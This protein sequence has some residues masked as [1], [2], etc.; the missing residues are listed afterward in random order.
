MRKSE[1]VIC[2]K[3]HYDAYLQRPC[4]PFT[5]IQRLAAEEGRIKLA[6]SAWICCCTALHNLNVKLSTFI[7]VESGA[8]LFIALPVIIH[9]SIQINLQHIVKMSIL[10]TYACFELCMTSDDLGSSRKI[11]QVENILQYLSDM[12]ASF[13][14][15]TELTSDAVFNI[16]IWQDIVATN[17]RCFMP[18]SSKSWYLS[19]QK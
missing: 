11:K 5:Y 9:T 13:A 17:F 15:I 12:L 16:K 19:L 4:N 6:T 18:P 1:I 14:S 3:T 8:K 7:A 2:D 10:G